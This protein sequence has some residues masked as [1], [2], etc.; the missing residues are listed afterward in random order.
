[1]RSRKP[2]NDVQQNDKRLRQKDNQ[3]SE[4][5]LSQKIDSF[6]VTVVNKKKVA[7][8][9]NIFLIIHQ[10]DTLICSV[11]I[12]GRKIELVQAI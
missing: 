1:M 7:D 3:R 12:L 5:G 11:I 9:Y 2:V 10:A 4:T 8:I 6:F